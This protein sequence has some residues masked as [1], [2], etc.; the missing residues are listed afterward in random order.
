MVTRLQTLGWPAWVL[1]LALI[2][3]IALAALLVT[4]A[5]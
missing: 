2:V 5:A 3:L 1:V 4:P